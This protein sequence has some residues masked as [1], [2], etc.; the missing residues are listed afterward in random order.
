MQ[1]LQIS[2]HPNNPLYAE[3][4]LQLVKRH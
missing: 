4:P 3:E 1:L 2:H